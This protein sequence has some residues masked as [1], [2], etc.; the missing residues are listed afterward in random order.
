[1]IASNVAPGDEVTVLLTG[2]GAHRARVSHRA[3]VY[4]VQV[5]Q[6]ATFNVRRNHGNGKE[7]SV[8]RYQLADE[9]STWARGWDT[10]DARALEATVL[11]QESAVD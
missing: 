10:E 7:Y 8:Y 4:S 3:R 5:P 1:M 11:L 6:V 2:T 9:G